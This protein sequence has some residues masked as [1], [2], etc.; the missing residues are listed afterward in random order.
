M[1]R[2]VLYFVLFAIA[3]TIVAALLSTDNEEPEVESVQESTPALGEDFANNIAESGRE[4]RITY[5]HTKPGEYSEI[6]VAFTAAQP[7]EDVQV[8]LLG[9]DTEPNVRTVTAD[10]N[11]NVYEVFTIYQFGQ[12]NFE[13]IP[14]VSGSRFSS[15][16]IV[17]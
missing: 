7:G 9:P 14:A 5:E 15:S 2:Y 3:V 4:L 8:T 1:N 11:G 17:E 13:V 16:I 10:E 6:F 12:Y